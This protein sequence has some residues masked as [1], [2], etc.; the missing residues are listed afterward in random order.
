[1]FPI[2][3]VA[4]FKI[5]VSVVTFTVIYRGRGSSWIRIPLAVSF[6]KIEQIRLATYYLDLKKKVFQNKGIDRQC[7]AVCLK[8][9]V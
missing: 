4:K 9:Y 2:H 6:K 1:M 3:I 8:K 7:D 5:D